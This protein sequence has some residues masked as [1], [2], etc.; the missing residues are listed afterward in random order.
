MT[1]PET[2]RTQAQFIQE[3]PKFRL[4]ANHERVSVP[5]PGYTIITPPWA[6][7]GEEPETQALYSDLQVCQQQLQ[8]QLMAGLLVPVPPSSFHLTLADLI[9][10]SA[11]R[12]ASSANPTFEEKLQQAIAQTFEQ[13]QNLAIKAKAIRL[14]VLGLA[15]MPRALAVCLAPVD[16][17]SYSCITEFR[18]SIYQNPDLITLGIEQ[19]YGFTAHITLGYFGSVPPDVNHEQLCD[20]LSA[21]N[22]RWLGTVESLVINW[23]ELR[24]FDDMTAYYRKPGWPVL[25]F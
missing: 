3:S 8:Q 10:D 20:I 1:L 12:E 5:F 24:K 22:D 11:Y 14:Q 15:I 7:L 17:Q 21:F 2:Y 18:R 19:Q 25:Q 4:Q 16:E 23:A 13:H 9:W 6:D